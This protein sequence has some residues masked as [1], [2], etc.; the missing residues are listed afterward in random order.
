M[1]STRRRPYEDRRRGESQK[2]VYEHR[3]VKSIR[4]RGSPDKALGAV[5]N[6]HRAR[7]IATYCFR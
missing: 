1:S 7:G 4:Q 5:R 3:A 2:V 6:D